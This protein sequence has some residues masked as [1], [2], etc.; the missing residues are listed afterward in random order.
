MSP[1]WRSRHCAPDQHDGTSRGTKTQCQDCSF[2]RNTGADNVR[3]RRD[4][5]RAH[6]R[7]ARHDP[8]PP[9]HLH[10]LETLRQGRRGEACRRNFPG[11][12]CDCLHHGMALANRPASCCADPWEPDSGKPKGRRSHGPRVA[13]VGSRPKERFWHKSGTASGRGLGKAA[14]IGK[15][16]PGQTRFKLGRLVEKAA[17]AVAEAGSLMH[18]G[19]E[20]FS[21][22]RR[23]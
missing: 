15:S 8:R 12:N 13:K 1:P 14:D 2:R 21:S 7:R 11:T 22:A 18:G 19:A 4:R 9:C 3:T 16:C 17:S 10:R 20:R 5:G 23:P 6:D